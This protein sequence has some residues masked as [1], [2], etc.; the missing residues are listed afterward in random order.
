MKNKTVMFI[1]D[2]HPETSGQAVI[3]NMVYNI[4]SNEANIFHVPLSYKN[5]NT[6]GNFFFR[7][8][9]LFR[10]ATKLFSFIIIKSNKKI[11]YF[12]PSRGKISIYRDFILIILLRIIKLNCNIK[13][14]SHLHGSDMKK[15]TDNFFIKDF[16]LKSYIKLNIFL[17][18]LSENHKNFAFGREYKNYKIIRNF[19]QSS[20]ISQ[21]IKPINNRFLQHKATYTKYEL[22]HLSGVLKNKGLDF[23]IKF[24][25][26]LNNYKF[27]FENKIIFSI[28]IVGW[29]RSDVI[30]LHPEI[31][32]F[33]R[34]SDRSEI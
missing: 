19:I 4:C 3:S 21:H 10:L 33:Y 18:I 8:S 28:K 23:A 15:S 13:I 7:I 6:R 14:F 5:D 27:F 32:S 34:I 16:F 9:F 29:N 26:A 2:I 22:L 30:R 12:T 24:T 25:L 11:I 20:S 31:S 17:I 1:A